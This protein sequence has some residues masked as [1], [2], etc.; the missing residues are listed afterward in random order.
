[1]GLMLRVAVAEGGEWE[2]ERRW[3]DRGEG[4]EGGVKTES[5]FSNR[6]R[7]NTWQFVRGLWWMGRG[8]RRWESSCL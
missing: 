1:M 6:F 3:E 8:A 7:G 5:T 4:G 2:G